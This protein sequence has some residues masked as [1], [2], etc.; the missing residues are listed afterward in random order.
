[1][2]RVPGAMVSGAYYETL[3]LNPALGRLLTREDDRPDA[4]LVAVS[5]MGIGSGSSCAVLKS[6][7]SR[8][9]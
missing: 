4:P 9:G 5:A 7:V 1:M 8:C 6:S 3:E 2:S